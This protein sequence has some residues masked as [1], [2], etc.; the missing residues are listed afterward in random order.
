MGTVSDLLGGSPPRK[1]RRVSLAVR[2]VLSERHT[3]FGGDYGFVVGVSGGADSLALT[4]AAA[5]VAERAEIPYSAL[6][7]DHAMRR[8][9]AE[10]A[11]SVVEYL[12]RLGVA[13]AKV[14]TVEKQGCNQGVASPEA[15][16]R[17]VRHELLEAE[18]RSWGADL[19]QVD[20]LL[21]HTMDDQAETVL[22]R[23]A[24]GS[25][26]G[27]IS[28]M[29]PVLG[30]DRL[31]ENPRIARVRPLLSVRRSDTEAFCSSL[32]LKVV[33]DPTNR[34]DGPWQTK[35]G[36]PLPRA[37]VRGTVLPALAAALGQDPVP[38]LART[39]ELARQD[40][41]AL[42]E[43]AES[44]VGEHLIAD[45]QGSSIP[46]YV[47]ASLPRAVK[48]RVLVRVAA[49]ARVTGLNFHQ[50][51]SLEQLVNSAKNAAGD[52]RIVDL[53]G[54]FVATRTDGNLQIRRAD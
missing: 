23:L 42:E 34:M 3:E 28:A 35:S 13:N 44:I 40:D 17:S 4:V 15:T 37:A 21:G 1:A 5:D 38:A 22:L 50:V 29:E 51:R 16:A 27:S 7:V 18:A 2:E 25:G 53:P 31:G 26:A 41:T 48:T 20:V 8:E 49:L 19:Q 52:Q 46:L 24:R 33:E 54:G 6:V 14:L 39:A 30:L 9:S 36:E 10:E 32:S 11:R 45:G 43:W 47:L 12:H